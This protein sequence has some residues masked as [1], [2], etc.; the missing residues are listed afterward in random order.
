MQNDDSYY[1]YSGTMLLGVYHSLVDAVI[2]YTFYE[3]YFE[4]P[5][6]TLTNFKGDILL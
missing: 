3:E 1:L 6:M 5:L 4:F 2:K